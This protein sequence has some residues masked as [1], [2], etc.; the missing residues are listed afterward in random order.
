MMI[1]QLNLPLFLLINATAASAPWMIFLALL[2]A[3][4]L[5]LL[6][7]LLAVFLWLWGNQQQLDTL[8]RL[9]VKTAL[10]MVIALV[11]SWFIGTIFPH[12][13]PFVAG[14]GQQFLPHAPDNS[15]PSDHGVVIFTF[16]F[17]FLFWHRWWSGL[18]LG[19][20]G[21]AIA[22]SRIYLGVHWPADMFG[23]AVLA[24]ICC[25]VVQL[26]WGCQQGNWSN[27]LFQTISRLYRFCFALPIRQ[28]WVKK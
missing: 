4:Y 24:F 2:I 11:L 23:A 18:G 28:R 3:R 10:T 13:R 17:G 5:I 27:M 19:L 9:L 15:F 6:V 25:M 20:L 14:V 22:W 1:E 26:L 21:C 12:P 7:P 8:R 16:A